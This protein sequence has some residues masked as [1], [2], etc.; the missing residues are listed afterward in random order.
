M[1]IKKIYFL[2]GLS[3]CGKSCA[4]EIAKFNG[5]FRLKIIYF[6][7]MIIQNKGMSMNS[8]SKEKSLNMFY[9]NT[10]EAFKE[11]R[12]YIYQ[13]MLINKCDA[14]SLESLYRSELA[15]SFIGDE[16]FKTEVIY[17]EVDLEKRAER[18]FLKESKNNPKLTFDDIK[19]QI[20]QKD[21]FKINNGVLKVKD[22]STK[23]VNNN[24]TLKQFK[25]KILKIYND[26]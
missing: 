26:K 8:E 21:K 12:D 18:E 4:G 15:K 25:E 6:E 11:F 16:R 22:V 9:K 19:K 5:I 2:S 14:I 23:I 7:K 13:F 3:E 17:I 24:G 10:E 1:E 20:E